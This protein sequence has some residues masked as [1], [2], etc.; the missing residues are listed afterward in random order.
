VTT[1]DLRPDRSDTTSSRVPV[2]AAIGLV[3]LVLVVIFGSL[4]VRHGPMWSSGSEARSSA[5]NQVELSLPAQQASR[6]QPVEEQTLRKAETAFDGEVV[7]VSGGAVT[8]AV[9]QWFAGKNQSP[10]VKI[11]L[12]RTSSALEGHFA[13]ENG[14]RYLLA[15]NGGTVLAC[16]FSGPWSPGLDAAYRAAFGTP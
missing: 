11:R 13:F 16:G 3:V 9:S 6:C 1:P 14:R 10:Q 4:L 8:I 15:A 5:T 12:G 2:L 7:D